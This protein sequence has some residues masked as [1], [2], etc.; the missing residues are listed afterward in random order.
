MQCQG[1]GSF[2]GGN[3][4]VYVIRRCFILWDFFFL[5]TTHVL[6]GGYDDLSFIL[7]VGAGCSLFNDEGKAGLW[8]WMLCTRPD[9]VGAYWRRMGL[10]KFSFV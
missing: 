9:N 3:G 10:A 8:S 2:F 5:Y 7:S 6:G 4:G 1:W